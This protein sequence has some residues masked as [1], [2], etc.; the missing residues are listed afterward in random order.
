MAGGPSAYGSTHLA[1]LDGERL[2][3]EALLKAASLL[4]YARTHPDDTAALADALE[5]TVE[6]WTV[7]QADVADAENPLS[8][9]TKERV[10]SLGA[11]MDN[12]ARELVGTFDAAT[13]R[14]MVEVHRNLA[15]RAP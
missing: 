1:N 9:E 6:L 7:F 8:K 4:E 14:A 5:F 11:F 10:L 15:G 2:E 13:L 3:R 12:A